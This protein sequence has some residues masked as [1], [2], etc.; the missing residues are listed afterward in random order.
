M[1]ARPD[2]MKVPKLRFREYSGPWLHNRL[3][4]FLQ[5]VGRPVNVEVGTTYQEI[6][7]RS[8]GKGIFHKP[9]DLGETLGEKR[10]FWVEPDALVLNIVF[11]WEQAIAL[12]TANEVGFIASHRFPMFLGREQRADTRFARD[13]FLRKYGKHLLELASPGGA[14]RNKTLGQSNFAEL[15]VHW[16]PLPE[17]QKIATFIGAIDARIGLLERR[18]NALAMYKKGIM[19]R[20]FAQVIRFRKPD[21]SSFPDW[22]ERQMAEVLT[23]H[24]KRSTGN[25]RVHSV[26]VHK[27][28]IDQI[29]HLGRSFSA[30]STDHYRLVKPGDIIYTK[31]PTGQF[32]FG[33]IK[34]N[35]LA[36]DVIVSPLYGVFTPETYA[37]GYIIDEH[38]V[39]PLNTHNY[40]H[41]LIQKGAKNTINIS[42]TGFL[43]GR[44]KLPV[45]P[46][47]QQK[48]ADYL[49]AM[50]GKIDA[51]ALQILA[52]QRL[53]QGLLQHMFV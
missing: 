30:A 36:Y 17:Q 5:K 47:E 25:E 10:V 41:Q 6:G 49:K 22:E 28:V 37:L 51:V 31:S 18:R 23:E 35:R 14:G 9:A 16:P 45:H 48:I 3:D 42:N 29:E 12:T 24:G 34:Q 52:L 38:F 33:I 43:Q 13:F 26:S 15:M 44:L 50:G 39:S 2:A 21:G 7:V 53:K 4:W 32:P 19:Q 20:L 1:N 27:G 11:A 8:H 40:L 46:D